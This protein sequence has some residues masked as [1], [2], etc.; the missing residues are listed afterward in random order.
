M[1]LSGSEH[2]A[3]ATFVVLRNGRCYLV[4]SKMVS[5]PADKTYQLWGFVN[6]KP[7][8]IGIMG[9]TPKQ[10]AFTL[11]SSPRPSSLAVTVEAAGGS[12]T[13]TTPLVASGT[14]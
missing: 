2:Q 11:A 9:S 14:V 1:T 6:G 10:V 7:V 4:D 5:L 13:P 12:L 8:S 3:L